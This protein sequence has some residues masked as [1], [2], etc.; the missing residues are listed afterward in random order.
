MAT[1]YTP[2]NTPAAMNMPMSAK[3][4]SR[5]AGGGSTPNT[6]SSTAS[7]VRPVYPH[8]PTAMQRLRSSVLTANGRTIA[9]VA[10]P[11]AWAEAS[12]P[13]RSAGV[14]HR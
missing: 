2:S 12:H 8:M 1:R 14:C 13:V 5:D 4:S 9:P 6:G 11:M 3:A 10:A 7:A